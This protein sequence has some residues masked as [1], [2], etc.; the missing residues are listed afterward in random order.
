MTTVLHGS[1]MLGAMV[2]VVFTKA[3]GTF[4]D[5]RRLRIT[6]FCMLLLTNA[7]CIPTDLQKVA[8]PW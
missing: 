2:D 5:K 6:S 1:T 7:S 3:A 4:A 8:E